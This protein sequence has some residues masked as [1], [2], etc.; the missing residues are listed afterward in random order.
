MHTLG[1]LAGSLMIIWPGRGKARTVAK[2]PGPGPAQIVTFGNRKSKNGEGREV[3]TA[4]PNCISTSRPSP[5][6]DFLFP[7][8]T[9]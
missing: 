9:I 8:V 1:W 4:F 3:E 2:D 5:F 7:N 6:F